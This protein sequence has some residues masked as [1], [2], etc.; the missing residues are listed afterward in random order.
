LRREKRRE[1]SGEKREE[2]EQYKSIYEVVGP[3]YR[4]MGVV[5][6]VEVQ[7]AEVVHSAVEK[8]SEVD[9]KPQQTQKQTQKSSQSSLRQYGQIIT[10]KQDVSTLLVAVANSLRDIDADFDLEIEERTV[11]LSLSL[12]LSLSL[13][14]SL[15]FSLL[16]SSHNAYV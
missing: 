4:D 6:V 12:S 5:G 3:Q 14:P 15:L 8:R 16:T 9:S 2:E 13:L 1:M 7:R 11:N 10:A